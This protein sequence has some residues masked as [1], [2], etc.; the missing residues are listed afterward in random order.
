M[1]NDRLVYHFR[2]AS[3]PVIGV[4]SLQHAKL[5]AVLRAIEN[6]P[7]LESAT[8]FCICTDCTQTLKKVQNLQTYVDNGYRSISK[9]KVLHVKDTVEAIY[10]ALSSR[11]D[12]QFRFIH[13]PARSFYMFYQDAYRLAVSASESRKR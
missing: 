1:E 4:Q 5:T 12:V 6:F 7:K 3:G 13:A 2:N 8:K 11:T 10:G 9:G